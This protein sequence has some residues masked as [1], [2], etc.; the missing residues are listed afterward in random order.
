MKSEYDVFVGHTLNF[1]YHRHDYNL[2]IS[3]SVSHVFRRVRIVEERANYLHRVRPSVG[4]SVCPS[5]LMCQ[6]G[7]SWELL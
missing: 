1:S 6:R 3:I 4:L 7:Y 5:I 2:F